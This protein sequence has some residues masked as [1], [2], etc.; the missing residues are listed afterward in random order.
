MHTDP[1]VWSRPWS[2]LVP[3]RLTE[4]PLFEYVCHEGNY[5]MTNLLTSSRAVEKKQ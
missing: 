4:G 5:R 2:G 3:W 1:T